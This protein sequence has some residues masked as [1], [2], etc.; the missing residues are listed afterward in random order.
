MQFNL[1]QFLFCGVINFKWHAIC[2][3]IN[4]FIYNLMNIYLKLYNLNLKFLVCKL[5]LHHSH[6]TTSTRTRNS[7]IRANTVN[8]YTMGQ[9]E[10]V[11]SNSKKKYVKISSSKNKRPSDGAE[12][13]IVTYSAWFNTPDAAE[14]AARG[15]ADTRPYTIEEIEEVG[16]CG[17]V[18]DAVLKYKI[19]PNFYSFFPHLK[20]LKLVNLEEGFELDSIIQLDSLEV[21]EV[22]GL[23]LSKGLPDE[24]FSS[25]YSLKELDLRGSNLKILP[26]SISL[27]GSLQILNLSNN[28]LREPLPDDVFTSMQSLRELYMFDAELVSIPSSLVIEDA[29]R[30]FS[31]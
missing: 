4:A 6:V 15:A 11:L 12:S 3:L 24:L 5:K 18:T 23:K 2:T 20:Y 28:N 27:L 7:Y 1:F 8:V 29:S 30:Q 22:S 26:E 31:N 16:K 9:G 25:T 21:L 13:D 19:P 17:A 10:S 14:G